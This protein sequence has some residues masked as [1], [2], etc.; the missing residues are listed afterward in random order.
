MKK[1]KK[2]K[3]SF[4]ELLSRFE[5]AQMDIANQHQRIKE[6]REQ[7]EAKQTFE[8]ENLE[9]IKARTELIKSMS[10]IAKACSSIMWSEKQL[11][12]DYQRIRNLEA[13]AQQAKLR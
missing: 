10:W 1:P 11:G 3:I 9:H 4:K 13:N 5:A 7:L 2:P 12:W 6:L 8:H